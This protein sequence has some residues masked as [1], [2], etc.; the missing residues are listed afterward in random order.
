MM[1]SLFSGVTGLKS[2]QTRMDVIGNNISNVN[3]IGYKKSTANFSDLYSETISPASAPNANSG[4]TNAKQVGLG[5]AVSSVVINNTPGASEY[6][7]NPLDLMIDGDGY[8]VLRTPTGNKYTRAGDFTTS[9]NGS[10]VNASGYF[11]QAFNAVYKTGDAGSAVSTGINGDSTSF[12]D[13]FAFNPNTA[14]VKTMNS[15]SYTFNLDSATGDLKVYKDGVD[16]TPAGGLNLGSATGPLTDTTTTTT[17]LG[18]TGALAAGDQYTLTIPD[19][20][21][22]TFN[23]TATVA[24]GGNSRYQDL[25]NVLN[26]AKVVVTNNDGFVPGNT[27]GDMTIDLSKYYNIS[28][29]EQGAIVGQLKVDYAPYPGS[30]TLKAGA[31]VVLGYLSLASFTN[32]AGLEKLGSNMYSD[33]PNSGNPTVGLAGQGGIG[34]IT[35]SSLEMSNVDLSEE[36]VNMIIT[37]RGFQANSRVIT[38]SDEMLQELVNLKRQ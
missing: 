3:T 20:G 12:F 17:G 4:G 13:T 21:T 1:R 26:N 29:N 38:T 2:H 25:A 24:A 37:E 15:G 34:N 22:I 7:G 31:N 5:V 28:I 11:V 6:T 27:M 32:P 19:L 10:L 30:G 33:T 36:M 23:T 9:S 16:I 35:P 14:G 18:D 8:F